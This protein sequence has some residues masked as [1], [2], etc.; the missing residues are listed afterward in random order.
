MTPSSVSPVAETLRS[1]LPS[2][3]DWGWV[4][5]DPSISEV[6]VNPNKTVFVQRSG[7]MSKI[8]ARVN[9]DDL[10]AGLQFLAGSLGKCFDESHPILDAMLPD[11][12]RVAATIA[13]ASPAGV[14]M[15]IRKFSPQRYTLEDL[16]SFGSMPDWVA[17]LIASSVRDRQTMV[18]SGSTDSGKTTLCNAALMHIPADER[19]GILEDTRELKVA[20]ENV[21]RFETREEQR[22]ND[23]TLQVVG[24]TM[25]Q[26]IK[27]CL[28][29]RPDRIIVGELRGPEAFDM[30]DGLN[31]GHEGSMSTI[32]A[33]TPDLALHRLVSF[34]MRAG[35]TVPYES[36]C[37]D[38][39][40]LIRLVVQA[41]R[42]DGK[43]FISEV[44]R[45]DGYDREKKAFRLDP[46]Y[47][48]EAA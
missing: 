48:R 20:H 43:R 8:D 14:C 42:A 30:L 32:H 36:I 1:F 27:D 38:A 12:S 5:T 34:A 18:V 45:V 10:A 44:A 47:R 15:T 31:T 28:R 26:L 22:D 6:M 21:F 33:N 17:E 9:Q 3:G 23:G 2:C 13:P 40:A 16:V 4:V 46:L 11:G 25:R 35:V 19:L 39:G 29:N 7:R 41:S 37:S 24:I